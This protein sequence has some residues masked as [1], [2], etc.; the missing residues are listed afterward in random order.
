MFTVLLGLVES[1]VTNDFS[2]APC[3]DWVRQSDHCQKYKARL[4]GSLPPHLSGVHLSQ[5]PWVI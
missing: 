3:D 5:L 1:R 2:N 4:A